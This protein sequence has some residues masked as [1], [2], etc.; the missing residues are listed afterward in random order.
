MPMRPIFD[1]EE[2]PKID[3]LT[4]EVMTEATGQMEPI[5]APT[6][7]V[8]PETGEEEQAAVGEREQMVPVMETELPGWMPRPFDNIP[9]QKT[10]L[11]TWMKTDDW[12]NLDE[13]GQR[14]SMDVYAGMLRA[15]AR[16]AQRAAQMQTE[17]AQEAGIKNAANP[18]AKPMPSLPALE[19]QPPEG[20]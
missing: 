4:G 16:E 17:M 7:M 6:G 2:G 20:T 3:P 8:N 1:G 13:A 5:M 9:V 11:T 12:A 15:E 10:V 18:P 14:A 19:Q